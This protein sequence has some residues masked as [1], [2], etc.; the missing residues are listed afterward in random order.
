MIVEYT[1]PKHPPIRFETDTDAIVIGR[2]PAPDQRVDIDLDAD[3]FV[4][5]V[6]ACIYQEEGQF[7][8]RD[9]GSVNGT[10]VDGVE[11]EEK[12]VVS[13]DTSITIGYTIFNVQMAF[14]EP[15]LFNP[16]LS[17][18]ETVRQE[19]SLEPPPEKSEPPPHEMETFQDTD[20][21]TVNPDFSDEYELTSKPPLEN[22][23]PPPH[24]METFQDTDH[25]TVNPDF[26]TSIE[27]TPSETR[28]REREKSI[29]TNRERPPFQEMS[30]TVVNPDLS[31]TDKNRLQPEIENATLINPEIIGQ[32]VTEK[33]AEAGE[34]L[35]T[36]ID[37]YIVDP[38]D[39]T[40][41]SF[42]V[43]GKED[44]LDDVLLQGLHQLRA[45]NEMFQALCSVENV[46]DVVE[47]L[48]AHLQKTIPN[49]FQ[50]ALMLTDQAGD[51]Q[52]RARWPGQKVQVSMTWAR[53]AF[54]ERD[55]FV[56]AASTEDILRKDLPASAAYHLIQSAI[57]LPLVAGP[58][59]FG[60]V[61]VDN[62]YDR[63]A[64]SATDLELLK[65]VA[66]QVALILKERCIP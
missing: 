14:D 55:A 21:T 2:R 60:V 35:A 53:K 59:R 20:H 26:S 65:A 40:L 7:W 63:E 42:S 36:G 31:F 43:S 18:A 16:D 41:H 62:Y 39:M 37:G 5:R 25:T 66:S 28:D 34:T 61:Y 33:A 19:S 51:L 47:I 32:P 52:V 15:T 57:Y 64:F 56:W 9:L 8:V 17:G 10:W 3:E 1:I 38:V 12:T 30:S 13:P 54:D 46:D 4:S 24:E 49:A 27:A 48:G 6:H 44:A 45:L 22:T 11:I 50:G 58:E 29:S 23:E